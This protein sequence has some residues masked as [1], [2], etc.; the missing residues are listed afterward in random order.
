MNPAPPVTRR[1]PARRD[2]RA[3]RLAGRPVDGTTVSW[4]S[5]ARWMARAVL[6]AATRRA[7]DT[8]GSAP[9]RTACEERL[10]LDAQRLAPIEREAHHVA[11]AAAADAGQRVPLGA[12]RGVLV[13]RQVLREVVER[14]TCRAR[15]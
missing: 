3:R 2:H 6:S 8:A 7:R 1:A 12:A 4:R 5:P 13:E 11:L 15:P 9:S 14:R 10:P